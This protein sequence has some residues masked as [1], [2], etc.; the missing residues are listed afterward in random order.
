MQNKWCQRF[1]SNQMSWCDFIFCSS[2]LRPL[3]K[4]PF[5][6]IKVLVIH[7]EITVFQQT[8]KHKQITTATVHI[9]EKQ[10]QVLMRKQIA[11]AN[12]SRRLWKATLNQSPK[13]H[14]KIQE[15]AVVLTRRTA[16]VVHAIMHVIHHHSLKSSLC[17]YRWQV[18]IR[19]RQAQMA[20]AFL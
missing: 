13:V 19:T 14:L 12:K 9:V 17:S 4:I 7:T 15:K 1:A 6:Y 18:R 3:C 20:P 2:W 5:Y 11:H 16:R 10:K 8:P